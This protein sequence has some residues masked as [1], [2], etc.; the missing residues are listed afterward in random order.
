MER[1]NRDEGVLW[2]VSK[3]ILGRDTL[4]RCATILA[5]KW[6][7]G[8]GEGKGNTSNKWI[9]LSKLGLGQKGADYK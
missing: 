3:Q 6:C 9:N 7:D 5:D 1:G 2:D 4:S 8:V